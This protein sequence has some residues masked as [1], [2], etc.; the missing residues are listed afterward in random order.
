MALKVAGGFA[1]A[2][3]SRRSLAA[4]TVFL[5][6]MLTAGTTRAQFSVLETSDMRLIYFTGLHSYLVPH[7]AGCF[8]KS[9]SFHR[10]LWD[11]E[12]S[13]KVTVFV[14]DFGDFLNIFLKKS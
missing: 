11:Y 9:M 13:E 2:R 1:Y 10:Q 5:I 12:P 7:V 8:E 14:H 6:V 3:L 4:A